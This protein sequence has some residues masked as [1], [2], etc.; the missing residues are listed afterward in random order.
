MKIRKRLL[1]RSMKHSLPF[2]FKQFE[3]SH[4][5]SSMKVGVD[6][7]LIGCWV[8]APEARSILDV[9]TGCGVVALICAQ[10]FPK[11]FI[12]AIDIDEESI[13]EATSNFRNSKFSDRL[14]ASV[15]DFLEIS[16]THKFDL[17]ISN[18]PF[19][20]S[21]LKNLKTSREKARHEQSLPLKDLISKAKRLL[22]N[23]GKI[24]LVLPC[25]R[26]KEL[27]ECVDSN[28]LSIRRITNVNGHKGAPLKRIL[29][30]ITGNGCDCKNCEETELTMMSQGLTPTEDYHKLT[31]DFYIKY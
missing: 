17:I 21:G 2:K 28:N 29:V 8:E 1:K 4:H 6:G 27:V 11:A 7:V 14:S 10:R 19:F 25:E 18:P 30:E 22:S 13:I 15:K 12:K 23:D 20:S 9:G 31:K 26:Y 16:E 5:R 24:A 3:V